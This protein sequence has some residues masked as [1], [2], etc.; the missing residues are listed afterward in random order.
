MHGPR[1]AEALDESRRSLAD[2]VHDALRREIVQGALPP[3][4]R[5]VEPRVA[6]ELNVSRTPVREALRKL[7]Q[8]GLVESQRGGPGL[9]VAQLTRQ[10]VEDLVGVR[11][12]LEGYAARLA[13]ERASSEHLATIRAAHEAGA[14][15]V[16]AK[17]VEALVRANNLF[18]D[19]ITEASN[20][21][22]CIELVS[23][24]R[25]WV[26]RYRRSILESPEA[27]MRSLQEHAVILE[28]LESRDG[29]YAEHEL[30]SHI[31]GIVEQ[32]IGVLD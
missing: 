9:Y 14:R 11:A 16:D 26:V 8:E 29:R 27:Q 6:A 17:D 15:A 20:S 12:V 30:R 10:S 23:T 19:T 1:L 3:G 22:R 32:I 31:S 24:L 4:L 2:Q 7:E 5:L 25:D 18:H 21:P 13:C 28:A